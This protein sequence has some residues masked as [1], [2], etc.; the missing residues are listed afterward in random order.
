VHSQR[1]RREQTDRIEFAT[2]GQ[3]IVRDGKAID[4]DELTRMVL[5]GQFY[6]LRHRFL[7]PRYELGPDRW[8]DVGLAPLFND[9]GG[10]TVERLREA[11][12][13]RP[14]AVD[15]A[16]FDRHRVI[17][18]LAAKGYTTADYSLE[19]DTLELRFKPGIYPH[20][21]VGVRADGTLLHVGIEGRS[22][23]VGVTLEQAAE[24]MVKLGARQSLVLDNG[25]DVFLNVQGEYLVGEAEG[26]EK[27]L[28]SVLFFKCEAASGVTGDLR[29]SRCRVAGRG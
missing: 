25:N 7:F 14:L 15:I 21:L 19:G 18:A 27:Q 23:R 29:V 24:L 16:Q 8:L 1:E 20:H 5:E 28:R 26:D 10:F 22:N 13:G 17:A 11:C 3:Q 12:A 6:D 2:Y 4:S 9:A